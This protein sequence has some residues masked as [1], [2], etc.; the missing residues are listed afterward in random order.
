MRN[1]T[2]FWVSIIGLVSV[3]FIVSLGTAKRVKATVSEVG[4]AQRDAG[5]ALAAAVK[6][7]V[8]ETDAKAESRDPLRHP[9]DRYQKPSAIRSL[10]EPELIAALNIYGSLVG[11]AALEYP[12]K[13]SGFDSLANIQKAATHL[14]AVDYAD[15]WNAESAQTN[16]VAATL[17]RKSQLKEA[18]ESIRDLIEWHDSRALETASEREKHLRGIDVAELVYQ[19]DSLS[20][21]DIVQISS[22]VK[23]PNI[24]KY[25]DLEVERRKEKKS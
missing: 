14:K 15:K 9:L 23:D 2:T 19:N 20:L 25:L 16:I 1:R 10:S 7:A 5:N 11:P 4:T 6:A 21:A 12:Y 13:N 8:P 22:E 3:P 24:K 18:R 17:L